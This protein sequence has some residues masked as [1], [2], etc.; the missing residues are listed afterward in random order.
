MRSKLLRWMMYGAILP[1]AL[2]CDVMIHAQQQYNPATQIAWPKI[3]G[4]GTPAATGTA[5]TSAKYGQPYQNTAVTPNTSYVCANQ[6]GTPTWQLVSGQGGTG[7]GVGAIVPSTN[8]TCSPLVSGSCTGPSVTVSATPGSGGPPTGTAGGDLGNTYPNP[9]VTGIKGVPFCT[10][11][12]PT[13]GQA[14]IYTTASTPNPCYTAASGV[15]LPTGTGIVAVNSSTGTVLAPGA[16]ATT[17][18]QDLGVN[19]ISVLNYGAKGTQQ[20]VT[21][22]MSASSAILIAS[23]PSFSAA[24]VG[25]IAVVPGAAASAGTLYTTVSSYTD[26]TH[27]TLA[28]PAATTASG[29]TAILAS[30]DTTAL[31][32][33]FSYIN[34]NGGCLYLPT[35]TYNT[36][37]ELFFA[38]AS[39]ISPQ[40][41]LCLRGDGDNNSLIVYLG[42]ST[43]D[44]AVGACLLSDNNICHTDIQNV[45]IGANTRASY[46]L[47][48]VRVI[49]PPA[50][51]DNVKVMGGS[52]SSF[53]GDFWNGQADIRNLEA[54]NSGINPLITA[55]STP[56][57]NGISFGSASWTPY[58][59]SA[60][61]YPSNQFTLIDPQAAACTGIGL[62][63]AQAF[64]V[65][66]K[67]GEF[68]QNYQNLLTQCTVAQC[69]FYGNTFDGAIFEGGGTV[70][71]IQNGANIFALVNAGSDAFQYFGGYNQT[72]NSQVGSV[73]IYSP[74]PKNN[75]ENSSFNGPF[76]DNGVGTGGFGNTTTQPVTYP[77]PASINQPV[78]AMDYVGTYSSG[79]TYNLGSVA[80]SPNGT[81]YISLTDSN[82]G[83]P[84][85][86]T[87][88]WHSVAGGNPSAA[89]MAALP[90]GAWGLACDESSTAGVPAAGVDY[91]RCD[92]AT[93]TMRYSFNGGAEAA[94]VGG[95]GGSG[96]TVG[97]TTI[98]GGTSGYIEYDNAGVLGE[99]ATTGSGSVVRATS[100]TLVTPALG[101]PS[102]LVLTNA[103]GLPLSTGVTGNLPVTNL[104]S[105]TSAS[106]STFWRG[107]GTWATP[108][109]GGSVTSF[110]AGNL[111][112]LFTTSV[113]TAT[114]TPAL[115]FALSNAAQNS[116]LAG[117]AT[118]GAGAPSYQTAPTL[119]AANMTGLPLST[120]VSGTLPV[121]NGGTGIG[122]T[123]T[124]IVRGGSPLTA[125]E[126][127]GDC[128]T[129]GS[130]AITCTKTSGTAFTGYATAT[131]VANTT[132]TVG[133][134]A[135]SANSCNTVATVSMTGLAT[136]MTIQISPSTDVSAVTGWSPGT[137]GQ[138]YFVDWP[139][140]GTLH[141]YVCNPTGTSITPGS[142]TTW[143]VSAR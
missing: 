132:L 87:T 49:A 74:A 73:Y 27:V 121:A 139:T 22:S 50:N 21:A 71:Q 4:S 60:S 58:G 92:A 129:S 91:I 23:T 37:A 136:S 126:L 127:S 69:A 119:S 128:T 118:G 34:T 65:T 56:C 104:N 85:T 67:G 42:S 19:T 88:Y 5:C 138:L 53:E 101:T 93:H 116:V 13:A 77:L 3:T 130:N 142:S 25:Q 61:T 30:N 131:F 96:L 29:V 41:T 16:L 84:L 120:G 79:T 98:S 14:L 46:A 141:Y 124:G 89:A 54:N 40:P 62:N 35:G 28:T 20:K 66:V 122:S 111:S 109:G 100:P 83:H 75:F 33:A 2:A 32:N 114:S 9:S 36:T 125:S 44:A 105:G 106:S 31:T 68:A 112:P 97:T 70:D 57:V 39:Q 113:A 140:S 133:T 47:H 1:G 81:A 72:L 64:S 26:S 82:S 137:G 95:S 143:N 15:T 18:L 24:S 103:T 10:G 76:N 6:G 108:S 8:V 110:S 17:G 117:P 78:S 59:L 86:N 134:T 115:T 80:L 38:G 43:V 11:F 55:G 123:L 51:I 45:G 48:A 94:L 7:S 12:T 102:A 107:D 135:I 52:V 63:L 90:S 99:L